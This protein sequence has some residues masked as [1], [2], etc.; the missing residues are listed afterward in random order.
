MKDDHGAQPMWLRWFLNPENTDEAAL[1][2]ALR[3]VPTEFW[4]SVSRDISRGLDE[5]S[6]TLEVAAGEALEDEAANVLSGRHPTLEM[7]R[8][9]L[10][11]EG[12][13]RSA[14]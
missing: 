14:S 7:K 3:V 8:A 13:R 1:F 5:L 10:A 11:Q 2:A 6:A 4:P 9:L 12:R